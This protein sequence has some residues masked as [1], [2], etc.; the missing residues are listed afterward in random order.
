VKQ[1]FRLYDDEGRAQRDVVAPVGGAQGTPLLEHVMKGGRRMH[2]SLPLAHVRARLTRELERLPAALRDLEPA[3]ETFQV[4]IATT[5]RA[6]AEEL[7]Q[8]ESAARARN[9]S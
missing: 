2:A 1:V 3:R 8:R 9:V 5:L 6:L 7:D 4:E